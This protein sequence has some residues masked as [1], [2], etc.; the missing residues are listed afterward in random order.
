MRSRCT[1]LDRSSSLRGSMLR[2]PNT[3]RRTGGPCIQACECEAVNG[4]FSPLTIQACIVLV[5][6]CACKRGR[7]DLARLRPVALVCPEAAPRTQGL[8]GTAVDAWQWLGLEGHHEGGRPQ[9]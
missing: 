3:W 7:G 1:M 4:F 9:I 6:M 2:Q 5:Q 8:H